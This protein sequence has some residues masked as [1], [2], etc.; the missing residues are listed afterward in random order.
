M[1]DINH[2]GRWL[3]IVGIGEDGLDGLSPAA[4]AR[5]QGAEL[6]VGGARHHAFVPDHVAERLTWPSP[7]ADAIPRLLAARGRRVVVLASGDPF[8]FGIGVTLARHVDVSEILSIPAPVPGLP[9]P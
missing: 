7:L 3:S 8:H 9:L 4:R 1:A 2:P 6:L 5:V